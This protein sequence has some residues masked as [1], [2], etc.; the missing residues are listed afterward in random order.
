MAGL[1]P[2][3]SSI[4]LARSFFLTRSLARSKRPFQFS[5]GTGVACQRGRVVAFYPRTPWNV[6]RSFFF[7]FFFF[8]RLFLESICVRGLCVE[9]LESRH[10]KF[11]VRDEMRR[12]P[13]ND[14]FEFERNERERERERYEIESNRDEMD[15]DGRGRRWTIVFSNLFRRDFEV[16]GVCLKGGRSLK[17]WRERAWI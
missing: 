4:S 1:P 5:A 12:R 2:L 14:A 6:Y 10:E 8:S 9:R 7:P 13:I 15:M 17:S 11:Q 16:R 3:F